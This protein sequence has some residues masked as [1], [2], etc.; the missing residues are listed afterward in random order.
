MADRNPQI[1]VYDHGVGEIGDFIIINE[2]DREIHIEIFHVKAANTDK[3]G[4]RVSYLYEVCGQAEKSLI[5]TKNR[6][7][8]LSKLNQR[9]EKA[10]DKVRIDG[11]QDKVKIGSP[12][13]IQDIFEADKVL[14]F[15]I[16]IVQ[17][18]LS[19]N[20]LSE[21][22]SHLLAA[23]DDYIRTNANNERLRVFCS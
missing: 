4:D 12:E 19:L 13:K 22:L 8:F 11:N 16:A 17:P 21:K 23:T 10:D 2:R 9:L 7:T 18:G 20:G 1:L 15:D 6:S 3:T 5:W 14:K